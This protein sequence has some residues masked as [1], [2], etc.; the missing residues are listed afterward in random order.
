MTSHL[1][2]AKSIKKRIYRIGE[3]EYFTRQGRF[4]SPCGLTDAFHCAVSSHDSARYERATRTRRDQIIGRRHS[5]SFGIH[6]CRMTHEPSAPQP[7]A[8]AAAKFTGSPRL[9]WIGL[10]IM[11]VLCCGCLSVRNSALERSVIAAGSNGDRSRSSKIALTSGEGRL[12]RDGAK[13]RDDVSGLDAENNRS[14]PDR[15]PSAASNAIAA[16][17]GRTDSPGP[18]AENSVTAAESRMTLWADVRQLPNRATDDFKALFTLE[19]AA[20]LGI[21][22]GG[23]AVIRNNADARVIQDYDQHGPRWGSVSNVFTHGG[24]AFLVEA[25]LLTAMYATSLCQQNEDLHELTL[26]IATS[27][28]FSVLAALTLQYATGTHRSGG[29]AFSLIQENGFPSEPSAATFALAAVV[30]ERYGWKGGVPAYLAAGLISFSQV[31]QNQH[32]VSEVFFGAALGYVIGKSI[33]AMHYHP[34]RP[35]KLVP[36]IDSNTG[37]QGLAFELRY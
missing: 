8:T 20:F 35:L 32:T 12:L 6:G 27:Y 19:N 2:T 10:S 24:D 21:A 22:G 15:S 23:A 5:M 13:R 9:T 29:S 25:P 4:S 31:D 28:K 7:D 18:F 1:S 34:E 36:F 37:S 14:L 17:C 16:N 33:G 3:L 11:T 30:E 26:T